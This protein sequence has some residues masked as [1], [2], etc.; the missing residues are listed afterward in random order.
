MFGPNGG[1]I[2]RRWNNGSIAAAMKKISLDV[3]YYGFNVRK[4]DTGEIIV[5]QKSNYREDSPMFNGHR[6]E[7]HAIL[8]DYVQSL[9]VEIHLGQRVERYWEMENRAGIELQDGK[10]VEGDVVV[11][12]DG[13]R[14]KARKYVL[15]Y[16]HP[17]KSSGYST[18]R[19][20]FSSEDM[21]AD[22]E[23]RQFV[24]NGD[25]SNGWIGLF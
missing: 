21:M 7:L 19:T 10:R 15:G 12:C 13:V 20:W 6:G 24:E 22:P 4:Y 14:S 23:T 9:G 18:Y 2:I 25:T 5:N 3:R 1:R 11:A 8:L 16:E 17:L